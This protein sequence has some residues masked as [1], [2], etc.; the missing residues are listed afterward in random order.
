MHVIRNVNCALKYGMMNLL[1]NK[2]NQY[3]DIDVDLM[4]RLN[5]THL[6]S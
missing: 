6:M 5:E 4:S 3:C 2:I 1:A